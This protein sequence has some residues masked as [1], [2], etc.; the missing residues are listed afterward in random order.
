MKLKL[1][2]SSIVGQANVPGS[3]AKVLRF[4]GV[5]ATPAVGNTPAKPHPNASLFKEDGWHINFELGNVT[6]EVADAHE[7]GKIY[8]VEIRE[9]G[10]NE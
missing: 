4:S 10:P 6:K 7:E 5:P 2:L 8:I 9:A 1:F 3:S